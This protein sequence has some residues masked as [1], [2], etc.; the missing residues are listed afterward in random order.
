M[1]RKNKTRSMMFNR[2]LSNQFYCGLDLGTQ[3]VKA[4]LVRAEDPHNLDLLAVLKKKQ[5]VLKMDLSVILARFLIVFV[6]YCNNYLKKHIRILKK[7][8]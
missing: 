7:F 2:L 8:I 3:K 5:A 1:E 6:K 4:S